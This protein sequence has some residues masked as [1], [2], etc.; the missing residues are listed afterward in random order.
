M[1]QN[2]SLDDIKTAIAGI[3]KSNKRPDCN[4]VHQDFKN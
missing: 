2:I 4:A 3:R 1:V